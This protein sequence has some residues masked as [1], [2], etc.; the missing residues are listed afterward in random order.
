[1][2]LENQ[3][4]FVTGANRGIGSAYVTALLDRGVGKVFLGARNP[5]SVSESL[6]GDS[7]VEVVRLD[8][9]DPK[10]VDDAARL[11]DDTSILINNAGVAT[12]GRLLDRPTQELQAL[13]DVNVFG[14]LNMVRAFAPGLI[15]R[16]GAVVNV[17]SAIAWFSPL[18]YGAYAASK[19]AAWSITNGIREELRPSGV[20]VQGVF[21]GAVD[22]DFASGY[23]GPM[24]S[25]S[26]VATAT[27]DGI[28]NDST[29]VLV[30]PES[31]QAKA[32]LTGEPNAYAVLQAAQ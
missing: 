10:T 7:R 14:S 31:R 3:V 25:P 30:D 20:L 4:A 12:G 11:A 26:L 29:E 13:L 5:E 16:G 23:D 21:F 28:E 15:S 22:T 6:A 27:L 32:A 9:T 17:V 19:A 2:K 18:A 8:V 24:I 1:M